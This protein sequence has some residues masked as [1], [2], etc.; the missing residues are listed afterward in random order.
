MQE[1]RLSDDQG[2]PQYKKLKIDSEPSSAL[3]AG[4]TDQ[5]SPIYEKAGSLDTSDRALNAGSNLEVNKFTNPSKQ[6]N[7]FINAPQDLS[8]RDEGQIPTALIF[9]Q[10]PPRSMIQASVDEQEAISGFLN[11][12]NKQE[13]ALFEESVFARGATQNK[14]DN[15]Q[16]TQSP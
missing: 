2:E 8:S 7:N 3:T 12:F 16:K 5:S 4:V 13:G 9:E 1:M 14:V 6:N 15:D 11:P 10:D